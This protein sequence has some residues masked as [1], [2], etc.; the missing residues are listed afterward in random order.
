[1]S[2]AVAGIVFNKNFTQILLIHRRDIPVWALP[3]GGIDSGETPEEAICREMWEETGLRVKVSRKVAIYEPRNKL[4]KR[5]HLFECIPIC[6][7]LEEKGE[8]VDDVAFFAIDHLPELPPPYYHWIT[9]ALKRE[10]TVLHQKIEGASYLVLL[11]F[12][13]L[14]PILVL[15]FLL[16]RMGLHYNTKHKK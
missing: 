15:R 7:H 8:E 9:D 11:K 2:E 14:R 3:G 1:M 6:G 10:S 4:A 13:F 16:S 12:L 5:T